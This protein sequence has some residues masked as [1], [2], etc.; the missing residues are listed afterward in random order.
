MVTVIEIVRAT[1]PDELSSWRKR[2]PDNILGVTIGNFD[3][4]HLGHQQLFLALEHELAN[5]QDCVSAE[6]EN[7]CLGKKK[8]VTRAMMSFHP[9]P[10]IAL[11]GVRRKE[12]SEN[13]AFWSLTPF[14]EKVELAQSLGFS[15]FLSLRFRHALYSLAPEEFVRKYLVEAL[16][17]SVV[18]VGHDWSFGKGKV[19]SVELLSELGRKFGFR[20]V[21]VPPYDLGDGRVSSSAVKEALFVGDMKRLRGLLGRNFFL[22]ARVSHGERRGTKIGFPT[23]NLCLVSTLLPPNGVYATKV[24]LG[25]KVFDSV[26]NIGV[27]PTFNGVVRRVEVH[28]LDVTKLDLY[29]KRVRLEFVQKLREEKKFSNVSEL[30]AAITNDI[31]EARKIL[32]LNSDDSSS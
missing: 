27:S 29:G 12:V 11:Q 28:L 1:K 30:Q 7:H 25:E 4:L 8:T 22:N 6:K 5:A 31:A 10:R 16:Q 19:G 32:G 18:V 3:G 2:N 20:V 14:R 15:L 23:A 9:H 26:S 13:P 24:H 17:V 21:V